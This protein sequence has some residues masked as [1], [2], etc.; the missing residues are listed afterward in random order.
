MRRAWL[1]S[2]GAVVVASAAFG[3]GAARGSAPLLKEVKTAGLPAKNCQYCHTVALPKK[4]TYTP[5]QLNGRG[6]WLLGEKS[7]RKADKVD[8]AWLKAY[9]G[10]P[11]QQ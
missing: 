4:E 2:V 3:A 9:P 7:K 8:P 5:E 1:W 10:G 11:E 6:K